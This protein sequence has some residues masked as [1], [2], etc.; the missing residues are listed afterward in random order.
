VSYK[1]GDHFTRR[2][3]REGYAAR[4]VYKLQEMQKKW[5]LLAKG[6]RV[7]DLGCA[8]GSWSRYA[9]EQIGF[10][11]TLVGVDIQ[12]VAGFP[13]L[14]LQTSIE[15]VL[16]DE[17]LGHLGGPAD[18]VMSDMAPNTMGNKFTD[19]LRQIAL[20]EAGRDL[21]LSILKPGGN[22]VAKVFEGRE[23]Q[24]FVQSLRAEFKTVKRIK[25]KATRDRSV[26]FFVAGIGKK[27]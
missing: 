21:A 14:F 9:H 19:H 10:G 3:Q 20:I 8:P 5:K 13:G 27:E 6:Q 23:A 1:K 18:L 25:P 26:E 4:S 17:M 16:V 2:A 7:L 11:G 24:S 22:F 12:E 15:D